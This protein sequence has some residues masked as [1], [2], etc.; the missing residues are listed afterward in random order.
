MTAFYELEQI[1]TEKGKTEMSENNAPKVTVL[2]PTFNRPGFLG[3]AI[4]SVLSQELENWEMIIVNDGGMKV[5]H[6]VDSFNDKRLIHIDNDK[7]KGKSACLNQALK[8]AKGEYVAYL[9]DDDIW[10]PNHLKALSEA[11]DRSDDSFGA[12]YSDLYGVQCVRNLEGSKRYPLHKWI[13]A[14]RDYNRF[15]TFNFNHVLH[16]SLMHTK[17]LADRV[18]GYDETVK[19]LIDW[20]MTRKLSF[21]TEFIHVPLLTGEYYM[22]FNITDR[23]SCNERVDKEKYK[24]NL[25]RTRADLP[26]E[27]WEKVKRVGVVFPINEWGEKTKEFVT[28]LADH[29][30]YPVRYVIINRDLSKNRDECLESLGELAE[31]KNIHI[32]CPEKEISPLESYRMRA[33]LFDFDYVYLP[34]VRNTQKRD[35]RIMT[36]VDFMEYIPSDGLKWGVP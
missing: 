23:I 36:A 30:S 7:N 21:F 31:L 15:F 11:L 19:V 34:S 33:Q 5:G 14:S 29:I 16:V 13:Q 3:E 12:A 9:D 35:H 22:P 1:L 24:H 10:Y 20:N 26:P 8:I 18:G 25:R 2:T 32:L 28:M 27:P 4:K 6:I 17:E